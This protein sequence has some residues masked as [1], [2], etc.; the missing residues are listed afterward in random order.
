VSSYAGLVPRLI[1]SGTM[2]RVGRITRRGPSLLRGMLPFNPTRAAH[3][4]AHERD[5]E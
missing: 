3:L 5:L 1:E 2:S 4:P